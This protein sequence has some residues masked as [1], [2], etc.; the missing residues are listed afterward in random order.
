MKEFAAATIN[1][2]RYV[3]LAQQQYKIKDDFKLVEDSLQ[4]LASRNFQIEGMVTE[5]VTEIKAAIKVQPRRTRRAPGQHR[6]RTAAAQH[7]GPQRSGPHAGR[8]HGTNAAANGQRL[9]P[10]RKPARNPGGKKGKGKKGKVPMDKITKGQGDLNRANERP[11]RA[12][13]G[14]GKKQGGKDPNG[15]KAGRRAKAAAK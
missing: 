9:C 4:A 15:S 11:E 6:Q 13:G 2:P 1:T 3:E 7:E 10:A 5:K 14:K 8:S 12:H